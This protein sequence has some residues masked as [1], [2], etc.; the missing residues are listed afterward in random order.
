MPVATAIFV[1]ARSFKAGLSAIQTAPGCLRIPCGS[2]DNWIP[3]DQATAPEAAFE[4][5]VAFHLHYWANCWPQQDRG[6]QEQPAAKRG[7]QASRPPLCF[8]HLHITLAPVRSPAKASQL[9]PHPDPSLHLSGFLHRVQQGS[10]SDG[11]SAALMPAPMSAETPAVPHPERSFAGSHFFFPQNENPQNCCYY[12][13]KSPEHPYY[14][15]IFIVLR[16]SR[17]LPPLGKTQL[18]ADPFPSL[19]STPDPGARKQLSGDCYFNKQK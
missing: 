17:S 5:N 18:K 15:G 3:I 1:F 14:V 9:S 12:Q 13:P 4:A 2:R 8:G 10:G 19:A 7:E 11:S 16:T 6:L